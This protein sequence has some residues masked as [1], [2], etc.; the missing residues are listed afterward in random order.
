M[1][2]VNKVVTAAG[3]V[4]LT[5]SLV[6]TP[7]ATA[8]A[9]VRSAVTQEMQEFGEVS[10]ASATKFKD[11][12]AD[13]WAYNGIMTAV[14]KGWFKGYTDGTFRPNNPVTRSE[15]AALV[16]RVSTLEGDGDGAEF[17]D[18]P[19][20]NWA[21]DGI[22]TAVNMGF[23]NP[24]DYV[25]GK[26]SPTQAMSRLEIGKW[27]SRGLAAKHETY[28]KALTDLE[29]TLL[30]FTEYYRGGFKAQDVPVVGMMAGTGI[31]IGLPDGSFGANKQ[32]TRAEVVALLTR[33][34][35]AEKK[36]AGMFRDLAEFREVG[37]TGTNANTMGVEQKDG[38]NYLKISDILGEALSAVD[39]KGNNFGTVT[40]YRYI[41]VDTDPTPTRARSAYYEMFTDNGKVLGVSGRY[42]VFVE[43]SVTPTR[44]INSLSTYGELSPGITGSRIF[45]ESSSKY[46]FTTVPN[47]YSSGKYKSEAQ[48]FSEMSGEKFWSEVLRTSDKEER[49]YSPEGKRAVFKW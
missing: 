11:V 23:V 17:V 24:G 43:L 4:V 15:F 44:A 2:K 31:M 13:H 19:S 8:A 5:V 40:A 45:G 10:I 16:A 49:L 3:I 38:E 9:N 47:D 48:F 41:F 29:G 20:S 7:I 42:S 14:E 21:A 30:P 35:E 34:V 28:A 1:S 46:G 39:A 22:S 18:V 36:T 26:F 12:S 32:V 37:L 27:L 25:G 33:Y 6:A